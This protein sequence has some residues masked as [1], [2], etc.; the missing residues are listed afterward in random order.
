MHDIPANHAKAHR[1]T[2]EYEPQH[3]RPI[4]THS[5]EYATSNDTRAPD[6][7][8]I[9]AAYMAHV[10]DNGPPQPAAGNMRE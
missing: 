10:G 3:Q 7:G 6:N 2:T 1:S 5:H 4:L 9:T 8:P